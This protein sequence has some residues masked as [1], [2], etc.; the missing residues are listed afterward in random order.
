M[1]TVLIVLCII[2]IAASIACAIATIIINSGWVMDL[3]QEII[4]PLIYFFL[5]IVIAV[6]GILVSIKC[7]ELLSL[8]K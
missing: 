1:T 7:D 5:V 8:W 3:W 4:L 2:A 6:G